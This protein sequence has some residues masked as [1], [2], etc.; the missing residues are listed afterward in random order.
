MKVSG[1]SASFLIG[2]SCSVLSLHLFLIMAKRIYHIKIFL[3]GL[4]STTQCSVTDRHAKLFC[5][6]HQYP[7]HRLEGFISALDLLL[8]PGRIVCQGNRLPMYLILIFVG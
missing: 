5:L 6:G 1:K 8:F 2:A 3:L 7:P 4:N